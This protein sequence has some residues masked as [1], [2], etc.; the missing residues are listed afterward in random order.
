VTD[1]PEQ[2]KYLEENPKKYLEYRKQIENELNQRFRFIFR[3]SKEAG[4]AREFS[5]S[6]MRK[7]LAEKPELADT[8]IPKDFNPG[9]RRPTPAP[10]YLEALV[11]PNVTVFTQSISSFD[12]TGFVDSESNQH[13]DVDAV[14]CA[15]GF[16]TS[17]LPRFPFIGRGGKNLSE[18]WGTSQGVTSYL[19][20][21]IPNF[22]NHFSFCGP[23]G[24][25]GHG[26]FM[27][28]IETWTTYIFAVLEKMQI[29]NIKSICPRERPA[30][31]FRA[32]ADLFLK[33]TAWTSPCRSWFKAGT[34]DGQTMIWPGSRLHHLELM[35]APR[36]EDFDIEYRTSNMFAFLGNGFDI[37][38]SDGRD[39]TYYLGSLSDDGSDLQPDYDDGLVE[40]L[41]GF[42]LD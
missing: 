11:Q 36:Y 31:D 37:R 35:K 38:E 3:G 18:E 9:C 41:K 25:V 5:M 7:K 4:D 32:H 10:G 33:R 34:V 19:C 16:D 6:Q 23:Y 39:I 28:L 2:L 17:W 26:S 8:I 29:E 21:A 30:Q 22:P 40:R 12:E 27:P 20:V 24:P 13:Y 15:T 42:S 1:T 14:I